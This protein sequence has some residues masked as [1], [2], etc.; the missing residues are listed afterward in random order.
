M[1]A[2]TL[3]IAAVRITPTRFPVVSRRADARVVRGTAMRRLALSWRA[4]LCARGAQAIGRIVERAERPVRFGV[5]Q[6]RVQSQ[7]PIHAPTQTHSHMHTHTHLNMH[8]HAALASPSA[9]ARDFAATQAEARV[10]L[11]P[12]VP[13][14]PPSAKIIALRESRAQQADSRA[15]ASHAGALSRMR[16]AAPP[17]VALLQMR[18]ADATLRAAP[19]HRIADARVAPAATARRDAPAFAPRDF[20]ARIETAAHRVFRSSGVRHAANVPVADAASHAGSR[21][22]G[23]ELIWPAARSARITLPAAPGSSFAP[24]FG[25]ASRFAPG[26]VFSSPHAE[27]AR[28]AS[29][30]SHTNQPGD[31]AA[32]SARTPSAAPA[33]ASASAPAFDAAA[34]DRLSDDVMRRIERKMRI[35]RQRRGL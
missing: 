28:H 35:E 31:A 27:S 32:W 4:R 10:A 23:V 9:T 12:L 7:T 15:P 14:S 34:L 17:R 22:D 33:S 29:H 19:A 21:D 1:H 16:N 20:P 3:A 2:K 25:G 5:T 24:G 30:T 26:A 18:R 11:A 13:F 8:A 6:W